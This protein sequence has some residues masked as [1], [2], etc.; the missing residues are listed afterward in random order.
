LRHRVSGCSVPII[1]GRRAASVAADLR[2][3][4]AAERC[5]TVQIMNGAMRVDIRKDRQN[6]SKAALKRS[7]SSGARMPKLKQKI[8]GCFRSESGMA[9]FCTIRSYLA[10]VRKQNRSL[11]DALALSFAGFVVSPLTADE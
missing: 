1:R 10:T 8:S 2:A 9:A 3:E 7:R 11:I 4:L 5:Q 6:R